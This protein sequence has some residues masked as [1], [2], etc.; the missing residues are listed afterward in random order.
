VTVDS[1]PGWAAVLASASSALI[2]AGLL[3][4]PPRILVT[5]NYAG[6]PVPAVLGF[7]LVPGVLLGVAVAAWAG[8]ARSVGAAEVAAA[9][10]LVL[11]GVAGLA[12]DLSSGGPKG[13]RGHLASLVAGR[14]TTGILKLAVGVTAGIVLGLLLG[15]GVVRMVASAV[16]I[17]ASVNVWNALDVVPGRALKWA[18]VP[19]GV[20]L[21]AGWTGPAGLVVGSALGAAVGILPFDLLERGMLGDAGSNPLGLVVGF[22]LAATLP[23]ALVVLGAV[24]VLALQA[25]AETVTISRLVEATGPLRWLDQVGRRS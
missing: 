7:A 1:W 19:L 15:G 11:A 10:A 22:G 16:L 13:L 3:G 20:A 23:T 2:A 5:A 8:P 24:T 14:P 18:L 25:A 17:A 12:D 9:V 4:S 6:R 21:L